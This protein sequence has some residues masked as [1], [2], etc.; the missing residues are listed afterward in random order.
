MS[1]FRQVFANFFASVAYSSGVSKYQ[2]FNGHD[3]HFDQELFLPFLDCDHISRWQSRH[4]GYH[5]I[6][7]R[8]TEPQCYASF[9]L[10]CHIKCKNV[11]TV[12]LIKLTKHDIMYVYA[13]FEN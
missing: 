7:V 3:K 8:N 9:R 12:L 6:G 4:Y 10:F 5:V 13:C 2:S 1:C 11:R